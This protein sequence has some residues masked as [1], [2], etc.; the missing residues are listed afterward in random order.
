MRFFMKHYL[1]LC[2]QD[3]WINPNVKFGYTRVI[4]LPRSGLSDKVFCSHPHVYLG[5]FANIEGQTIEANTKLPKDIF[6]NLLQ[7]LV[8]TEFLCKFQKQMVVREASIIKPLVYL[9]RYSKGWMIFDIPG[10][11]LWGMGIMKYGEGDGN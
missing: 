6:A 2:L 4:N 3:S 7:T 9:R 5:R 8:I 10:I 11:C 1:K